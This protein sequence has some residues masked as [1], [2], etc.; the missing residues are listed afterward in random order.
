MSQP[1]TGAG[2]L[3]RAE[4]T[5]QG[6]A[7]QDSTRPVLPFDSRSLEARD[8]LEAADSRPRQERQINPN[9]GEHDRVAAADGPAVDNRGVNAD[10]YCVLLSSGPQDS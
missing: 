1:D 2:Q 5:K 7:G 3:E 8:V 9:S 4:S 6:F 10:V